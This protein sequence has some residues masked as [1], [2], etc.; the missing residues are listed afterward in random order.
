MLTIKNK[1]IITLIREENYI[2]HKL[3]DVNQFEVG[4]YQCNLA[5]TISVF[6]TKALFN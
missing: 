3:A 6:T 4:L 1:C 2:L 5:Y